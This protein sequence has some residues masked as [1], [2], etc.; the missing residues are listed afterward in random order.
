MSNCGSSVLFSLF[1]GH[2]IEKVI[3]Y[4]IGVWSDDVYILLKLTIISF[5]CWYYQIKLIY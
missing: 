2:G 1:S 5:Y 3:G 4:Q